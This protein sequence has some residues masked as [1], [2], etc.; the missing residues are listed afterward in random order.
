MEQNKKNGSSKSTVLSNSDPLGIKRTILGGDS[1]S[2]Q[3]EA[4]IVSRQ[5]ESKNGNNCTECEN[6]QSKG[7]KRSS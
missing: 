1:P 5:W 6:E 4:R 3:V 2:L 7:Q